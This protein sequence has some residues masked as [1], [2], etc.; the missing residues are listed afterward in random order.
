MDRIAPPS[1]NYDNVLPLAIES[2]SNRRTFL[3]VNGQKFSNGTGST[4]IRI[5][6]NADSMLD[7]THSYLSVDLTN[8]KPDLVPTNATDQLTRIL[9]PEIG[10][11]FIQRLRI[12][13]GGV[14]IEDINE[15]GRLYT[16]MMLHQCPEDY[17]NNVCGAYNLYPK[18][19]SAATAPAAQIDGAVPCAGGGMTG[20]DAAADTIPF[21]GALPDSE[22]TYL[23]DKTAI[24][25]GVLNHT[26]AAVVAGAAALG[27][28]QAGT[29]HFA[30]LDMDKGNA[31][32]TGKSKT[33]TIPLLSGFLNQDKYIP[34]IMMNAGFTIEIHLAPVNA[35][36]ITKEILVAIGGRNGT[37]PAAAT[38]A[39]AAV[40]NE[41]SL[42]NVKYVANLIDL[43][44]EFYGRL[45]SVMEESGG[46]LQLAGQTYRHYSAVIPNGGGEQTISL[47]ARVK[48]IK[49]IFG[50]FVNQAHRNSNAS[51]NTSVFHNANITSFRF[52]IGSV[53]YPQTDISMAVGK[54]AEVMSELHKAFG[55]LGDYSHSSSVR[56]ACL[57][58]KESARDTSVAGCGLAG[59]MLGYDFEAFQKVALESGINTADRSLP[60]NFV[61]N[62][63]A[64]SG[65][66]KHH[67]DFYVLSDAI[68]YI[69]LDGTCSVSV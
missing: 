4:I 68:Y 22:I 36:G 55:K 14:T 21:N 7:P 9:H 24:A 19:N 50:T 52:E 60:L 62:K 1:L 42:T 58:C 34:L 17:V 15:Y 49:S 45:R 31:I 29:T 25:N 69:N 44:R 65:T 20:L 38:V 11:A 12:E 64:S 63:S 23:Q 61:Y 51:Y 2:R 53:R 8:D 56:P 59:F 43:D 41:W 37:N 28:T 35:V 66:V 26:A 5:D 32:R 39:A 67:A 30:M 16:A 13:S 57:E 46:V 40:D 6:V 27:A 48:S 47:P 10:P 18:Q 33:I 54:K 3:P